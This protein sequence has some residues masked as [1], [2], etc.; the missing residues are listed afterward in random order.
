LVCIL[1]V[2]SVGGWNTVS[3]IRVEIVPKIRKMQSRDENT[4]TRFF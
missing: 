3:W 1:P 4:L 2:C